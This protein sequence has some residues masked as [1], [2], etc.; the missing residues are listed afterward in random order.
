MKMTPFRRHRT[1]TRMDGRWWREQ[2]RAIPN[3]A[4]YLLFNHNWW[5]GDAL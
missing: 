3:P 1:R 4:C 2:H 5:A